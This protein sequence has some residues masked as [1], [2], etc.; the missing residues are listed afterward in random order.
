MTSILPFPIAAVSAPAGGQAL[1][2]RSPH[3]ITYFFGSPLI[4]TTLK[5][6][7]HSGLDTS[8]I[9]E[10]HVCLRLPS[11]I[12]PGECASA[13]SHTLEAMLGF[14]EQESG[15]GLLSPKQ[16]FIDFTELLF[17]LLLIGLSL[18]YP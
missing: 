12:V 14:G 10:S 1:D 13:T 9:S 6:Q 3:P 17:I 7:W 2:P 18:F 8:R 15:P 11:T 4:G 16:H 5:E